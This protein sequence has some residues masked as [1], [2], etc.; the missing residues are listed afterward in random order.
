[1]N[2]RSSSPTEL[3][4]S[5]SESKEEN[6]ILFAFAEARVAKELLGKY[7]KIKKSQIVATKRIGIDYA[8]AWAGKPWRF[9]IKDNPFISRK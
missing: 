6:E 2:I 1:M 3:L 5:K 8:G 9:Y 4:R 7:F